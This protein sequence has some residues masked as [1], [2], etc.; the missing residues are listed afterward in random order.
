M[1]DRLSDKLKDLSA[2]LPETKTLEKKLDAMARLEPKVGRALTKLE[3]INALPTP[4]ELKA[5]EGQAHRVIK[6]IN[7]ATDGGHRLGKMDFKHAA[8][9][10]GRTLASDRVEEEVQ[11]NARLKS[12]R[13]AVNGVKEAVASQAGADEVNPRLEEAVKKAEKA[14]ET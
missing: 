2:E 11:R 6:L 3:E 12:I 9:D 13:K 14:A 1:A 7:K 10:K 5:R 8:H 4:D